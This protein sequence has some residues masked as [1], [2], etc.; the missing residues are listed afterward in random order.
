MRVGIDIY[1]TLPETP[2]PNTLQWVGIGPGWRVNQQPVAVP[3]LAPYRIRRVNLD[4]RVNLNELAFGTRQPLAVNFEHGFHGSDNRVQFV[5]PAAAAYRHAGPPV[6][7]GSLGDWREAD[8]IADGPLVKMFDRLSLQ[9]QRLVRTSASAN[10][11][12]GWS[13]DNLYIAFRMTDVEGSTGR[14]TKNFIDYQARRA[15]GEDICELL[16]QPMYADNSI[17]PLL[18]VTC[19]TTGTLWVE[20]KLDARVNFNPWTP[21]EGSKVRYAASLDDARIWRGELA[22]PWTAVNDPTKGRPTLLRVNFSA[23][24]RSNGESGSW[25]GPVDY[26]RDENFMGM[27]YL[28]DGE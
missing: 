15:W 20:R 13:D 1:S 21:L 5:A 26:G 8:A 27:I 12:A 24:N 25:A 6:V 23:H 16:V 14:A 4:A 10:V 22:I 18:N 9:R 28:R 11:Y 19:K 3:P 7:D 17:G 2:V